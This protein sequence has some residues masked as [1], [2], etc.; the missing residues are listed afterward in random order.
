[1]PGK[2]SKKLFDIFPGEFP[3]G[4]VY[5]TLGMEVDAGDVKF[6]AAAQQ[7]A[8]RRHEHDIPLII[9]HLSQVLNDPLYIG[10]DHRN[11]GKIEFVRAIPGTGKSAL[12]AVTVEKDESDGYY[13]VC[14]SYLIT[15]SEV[16]KKRHKGILKHAKKK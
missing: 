7:H 9:P 4:M 14:S 13:H 1:M 16:D 3:D 6:S 2:H 8:H 12:I 11:P 15:Q 10:D 5:Y